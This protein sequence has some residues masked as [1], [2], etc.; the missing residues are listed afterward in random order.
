MGHPSDLAWLTW[1]L[2]VCP[3]LP[4]PSV[5]LSAATVLSVCMASVGVPECAGGIAEGRELKPHCAVPAT[6]GQKPK[7]NRDRCS[8]SI[9]HLKDVLGKLVSGPQPGLGFTQLWV[10]S[11]SQMTS[12]SGG[13]SPGMNGD[14]GRHRETPATAP[15]SCG[16]WAR[17]DL[18]GDHLRLAC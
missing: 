15:S 5:A 14:H 6:K 7:L 10:L 1:P 12:F 8:A 18:S 13:Q 4:G 9:W 2:F 11:K 16:T 3:P 17:C